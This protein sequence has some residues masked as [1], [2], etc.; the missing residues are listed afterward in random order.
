MYTTRLIPAARFEDRLVG[1]G[2]ELATKGRR[3]VGAV[4][5]A[6]LD[7]PN[8]IEDARRVPDSEQ[9][10]KL[11]ERLSAHK[12]PVMMALRPTFPFNVVSRSEVDSLLRS[13]P[14]AVNVVLGEIL[15][16]DTAGEIAERLRIPAT[17]DN[18]VVGKLTFLRQPSSWR[19]RYLPEETTH[20]RHVC[21]LLSKQY[22]LRSISA[23][24][25]FRSYWNLARGSSAYSAGDPLDLSAEEVA[26]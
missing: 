10:L 22:F 2:N 25:Y 18:D 23:M 13:V 9:R 16:L 20:A 17:H 19:K 5:V 14:P 15:L 26:P 12:Q 24:R 7:F 21:E 11:L 3:F 1:L 8:A 6:T 4:S